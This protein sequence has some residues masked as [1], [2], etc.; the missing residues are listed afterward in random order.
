VI[1]GLCGYAQSGKDTAAAHLVESHGWARVAFADPLR[2]MMLELN[3][4]VP[5]ETGVYL[6]LRRLV[7]T[8]GWDEAKKNPEVRRLLQALGT[9]AGR[10][11][12]GDDIWVDVAAKKIRKLFPQNVVLTDVRFEN[13]ARMI[14][15]MKGRVI[16]IERPGVG[17]VN[18]HVS[19][20]GIPDRYISEVIVNGGGIGDLCSKIERSVSLS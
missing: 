17:A 5:M 3:P 2:E 16:R 15:G 6:R 13:E 20:N 4:V 19:E 18:G 11:V 10:K 1:I 7:E 14:L 8:S 12:L 9:E